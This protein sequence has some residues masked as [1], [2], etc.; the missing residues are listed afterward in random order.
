MSRIRRMSTEGSDERIRFM[1]SVHIGDVL[2]YDLALNIL[3]L[4]ILE[5]RAIASI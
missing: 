1:P 3:K 5:C 4:N 2:A